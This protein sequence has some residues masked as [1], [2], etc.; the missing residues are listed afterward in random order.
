M[1]RH[2]NSISGG[3]DDDISLRFGVAALGFD[4]KMVR[5]FVDKLPLVPVHVIKRVRSALLLGLKD[6][7]IPK[8]IHRFV[9]SILKNGIHTFC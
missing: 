9:L 2:E 5:I 1:A 4:S 6:E 8:L 3:G 7:K